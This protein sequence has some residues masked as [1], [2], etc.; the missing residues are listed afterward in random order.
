VLH[1]QS[2]LEPGLEV[3]DLIAHTAGGQRR[4]ELARKPGHTKDFE[5]TYWHSPIPPEFMAI[6]S[7]D[8]AE[9]VQGGLNVPRR[10]E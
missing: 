6:T 1:A 2:S 7:V 8:I 5:K 10:E 3:A 4:H 9:A